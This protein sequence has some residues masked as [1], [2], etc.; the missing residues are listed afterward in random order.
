MFSSRALMWGKTS[1]TLVIASP[2]TKSKPVRA[3]SK[4]TLPSHSLRKPD[5]AIYAYTLKE[6]DTY[7]RSQASTP[8]G[9]ALGWAE[10]VQPSDIVFSDDI[11]ENLKAGKAF[12]FRT[13]KVHLGRAYEAVDQLEDVTGLKLAGSHPRVPITPVIRKPGAKL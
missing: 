8:R 13:I 6:V 5:P 11:G 3:K 7:A 12:G 1:P 9:K 4:L 10:G 2:I